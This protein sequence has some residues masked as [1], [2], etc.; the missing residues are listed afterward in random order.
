M[1]L[2]SEVLELSRRDDVAVTAHVFDKRTG[3]LLFE[4]P[5]DSGQLLNPPV[6]QPNRKAHQQKPNHQTE[7]QDRV[8]D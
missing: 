7:R 3:D 5:A 6:N 8:Q 2:R 4:F 1:K